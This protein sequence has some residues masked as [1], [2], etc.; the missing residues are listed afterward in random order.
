MRTHDNSNQTTR[1]A[2]KAGDLNS[3]EDVLRTF[4]ERDLK[5]AKVGVF[6]IDGVLRGKLINRD[7]FTSALDKG[8]GFCDVIFG[9]VTLMHEKHSRTFGE[10]G[11]PIESTL[12]YHVIIMLESKKIDSE[13]LTVREALFK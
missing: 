7:K 2:L 8:F 5:Y 11:K 12:R 4:D 6:D 3:S 10:Q 1:I 13:G 9:W